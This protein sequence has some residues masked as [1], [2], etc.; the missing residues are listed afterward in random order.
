MFL[1]ANADEPWVVVTR[2][3]EKCSCLDGL[4]PFKVLPKGGNCT[5]A[6][7]SV[8]AG[9]APG[10]AKVCPM[11]MRWEMTAF[12]KGAVFECMLDEPQVMFHFVVDDIVV[13]A[14]V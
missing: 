3:M 5:V 10:G 4:G 2:D 1:C 11:W 7:C 6:P 9:I 12:Q 8:K 14:L 13:C